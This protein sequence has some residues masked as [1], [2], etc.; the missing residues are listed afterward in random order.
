MKKLTA[1]THGGS[2]FSNTINTIAELEP[3]ATTD[4]EGFTVSS[5]VSI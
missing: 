4:R 1:N 5:G 3:G 2:G